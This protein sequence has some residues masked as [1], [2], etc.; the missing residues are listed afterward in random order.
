[1]DA[2]AAE[3]EAM[4]RDSV[5]RWVPQNDLKRKYDIVVFGA[6]GFTGQFVVLETARF[7]EMY[8]LTWAVAGRSIDKIQKVLA[9][10]CKT[11]GKF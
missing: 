1:M 8:S 4:K 11:L 9:K 3:N 2:E 6:S 5:D 7:C 10:M